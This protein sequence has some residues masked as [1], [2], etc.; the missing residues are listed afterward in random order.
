MK[1]LAF[2]RKTLP[3]GIPITYANQ[4][5]L[6]MRSLNQQNSP[7]GCPANPLAHS[8]I[9]SHLL[10]CSRGENPKAMDKGKKPIEEDS[11]PPKKR[12]IRE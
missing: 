8:S 9:T 10:T 7:L 2:G 12:T 11:T 3:L 6:P 5:S 4:S 1:P